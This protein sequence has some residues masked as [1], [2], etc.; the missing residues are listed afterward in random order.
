MIGSWYWST[1]SSCIAGETSDMLCASQKPHRSQRRTLPSRPSAGS[2]SLNPKPPENPGD[3]LKVLY[4]DLAFRGVQ[5]WPS[6][7]RPALERMAPTDPALKALYIVRDTLLAADGNAYANSLVDLLRTQADQLRGED[8]VVLT[9]LACR[10][11]GGDAWRTFRENSRDLL[12]RQPLSG[13]VVTLVS[14]LS[15]APLPAVAVRE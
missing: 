9:A 3:L 8:I 7:K 10:R 4:A 5:G 2:S 12:G 6:R 13:G 11:A 14:N 1:N 15:K